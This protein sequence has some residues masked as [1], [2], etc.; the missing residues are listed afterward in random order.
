MSLF[1]DAFAGA[2]EEW[3]RVAGEPFRIDALEFTAITIEELTVEKRAMLG[4]VFVNAATRIL[5]SAATRVASGV[6]KGTILTMR[7]GVRVRVTNEPVDT[8]GDGTFWLACGPVQI[9]PPDL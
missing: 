5:I 2:N 3:E 6:V 8:D 9:K 4:G 7:G 1:N